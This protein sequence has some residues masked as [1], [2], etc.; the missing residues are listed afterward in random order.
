MKETNI[1]IVL[2]DDEPRSLKRMNILLKNFPEVQVLEQFDDAENAMPF[3]L[4]N[5]P[6]MAFLDIEMPGKTGLE[7]AEEI[8]K[9]NLHTKV[10]F[11][12]A[13]DH[14]AIKAIKTNAFDY[15][16]KPVGLDDLKQAIVRYKA[17]M[18]SNLNKREHEILGFIGKGLNS[19]AIAK[20]LF[21]SHHTVDTYRRKILKKTGCSN[22]AELIMYATKHNLI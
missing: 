3:I 1:R 8:Q 18:Q 16:V 11:I 9:N 12:S 4:Q 22:A 2:V 7:I 20:Q 15:L 5:E 21:L 14:Y 17:T 10:I 13:H 19:K 6:D